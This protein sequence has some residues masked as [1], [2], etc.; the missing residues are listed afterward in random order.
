MSNL[1]GASDLVVGYDERPVLREVSFELRAGEVLCLLGHNG[2]G[3]STLLKS[4]F[5][6]VPRRSGEIFLDGQPVAATDPRQMV[7]AG[8]SLIPEGRGIFPAL[9]VAENFR[10]GMW[11]AGVP[12]AERPE[13]LEWVLSTLPDIKKFYERPAGTLSGGQQQMVSIGRA[14]LSRPRCLL[15]DE[16]S[17]GLAPKLFEDLMQPVRELQ[18]STGMSIL[19]VEQNVFEALKMSDRVIVM[20]AGELIWSGVPEELQGNSQLREK[21]KELY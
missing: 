1:L 5:G 21:L 18:Q 19:L 6:L 4:L 12:E 10:L 16:P 7:Q 3:K 9:T 13:R 15:M 17:I 8:I 14:L 20:K 2:A 11:S